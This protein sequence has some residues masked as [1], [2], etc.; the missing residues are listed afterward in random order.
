[1]AGNQHMTLSIAISMY[2]ASA[3]L[4]CL[5]AAN[6]SCQKGKPWPSVTVKCH[7]ETCHLGARGVRFMSARR[8]P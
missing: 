4:Q 8:Q 6:G 7:V 2:I 3:A 5:F 1:M